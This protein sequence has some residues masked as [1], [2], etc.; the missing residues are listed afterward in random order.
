[1]TIEGVRV[2][3]ATAA[4]DGLAFGDDVDSIAVRDVGDRAR[5]VEAACAALG[6]TPIRVRATSDLAAL[7]RDLRASRCDV[8]FSLVESIEG[9]ARM[10]AAAAFVFEWLGLPF[11]GSPPETL[12][13]A[14]DKPR[15]RDVLRGRGVAVPVGMIV[16]NGNED[17]SALRLP[18]IVKPS[19]EDASHGV[20]N[21]SVVDTHLAATER[22]IY[23]IERYRQPALVEEFVAGREFNLSLLGPPQAP[24]ILP[25]VEM[26]YEK[27]P[28]G[29]PRLVGYEA[30][31]MPGTPEFEGTIPRPA[32]DLE[33]GV[34]ARLAAAAAM[35]YDAIGLRDY[36]RVDLRLD[37]N[38]KP[39]VLDVNPNPDIVAEA[40]IAGLL[41]AARLAGWTYENL[42][43]YLIEQ[44]LA[45]A[46]AAAGFPGAY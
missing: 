45:R 39:L 14:L 13:L 36:G 4:D 26:G 6:A 20:R 24:E 18:V 2:A 43:A 40:G 41:G 1:V 46:R 42:I 33:P 23:V 15:T 17:L 35:A 30:K 37:R 34:A 22:A 19:R 21:A 8:V 12:A 27:L 32:V 16:S 3:I 5:E 38:L 25:I 29:L 10:E 28:A 7:V 9:N 31:W 44:A 11:T